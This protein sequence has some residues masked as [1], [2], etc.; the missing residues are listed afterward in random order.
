M[1]TLIFRPWSGVEPTPLT[2]WAVE[3]AWL[4]LGLARRFPLV[5]DF[6]PAGLTFWPD[7]CG[8]ESISSGW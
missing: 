8:V 2:G 6:L 7:A 5:S 3:L 1:W 4:N